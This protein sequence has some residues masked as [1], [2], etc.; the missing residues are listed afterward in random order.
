MSI[1][2]SPYTPNKKKK[3]IIIVQLNAFVAVHAYLKIAHLF[4]I[5]FQHIVNVWITVN[6]SLFEVIFYLNFGCRFNSNLIL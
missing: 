2:C 5:Y 4:A 6:L 1:K 3:K